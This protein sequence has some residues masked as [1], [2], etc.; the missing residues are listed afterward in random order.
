MAHDVQ[1]ALSKELVKEQK[2][3][4]VESKS[5]AVSEFLTQ[6]VKGFSKS[7]E[8]LRLDDEDKRIPGIV[9]G[10]FAIYV[11]RIYRESGGESISLDSAFRAIESLCQWQDADVENLIV[12]EILENISFNDCPN[13]LQRLGCKS[14]SL[15]KRWV[16]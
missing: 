10:A 7:D 9:C 12:T 6:E 15:Y 8:Y 1:D 4:L 11:S 2:F 3:I 5:A 13:L 16:K 14:L